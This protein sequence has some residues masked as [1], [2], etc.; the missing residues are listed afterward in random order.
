MSTSAPRR[1]RASPASRSGSCGGLRTPLRNPVGDAVHSEVA[2]EAVAPAEEDVDEVV[3]RGVDKREGHRP[4]VEREEDA[5]PPGCEAPEKERDEERVRRVQR[6]DGG[7]RVGVLR[8]L[9]EQ[10]VEVRDGAVAPDD[11]DRAGGRGHIPVAHFSTVVEKGTQY[12]TS[13]S[14][15]KCATGMWLQM[16]PIERV[17]TLFELAYCVPF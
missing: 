10:R 15:L 4:R 7:D 1:R 16:I 3:L 8:P 14:V 6:R 5:A 2:N 12:A 9:L 11:A 17:N 13:N